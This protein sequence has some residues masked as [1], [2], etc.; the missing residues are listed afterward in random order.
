MN[1]ESQ[2][3]VAEYLFYR[4]SIGLVRISLSQATHK[5]ILLSLVKPGDITREAVFATVAE[6]RLE[7]VREGG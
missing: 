5:Q 2:S 7:V 3:R 4:R 6:I 1:R